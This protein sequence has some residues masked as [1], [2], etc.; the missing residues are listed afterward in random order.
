VADRKAKTAMDSLFS[1]GGWEKLYVVR[2]DASRE[3]IY[4]S[5]DNLP[6]TAA[7]ARG[8]TAMSNLLAAL[9][10]SLSFFPI[11]RE[12]TVA[13]SWHHLVALEFDER[14]RTLV[15]NWNRELAAA[16]NIDTAAVDLAF[17]DRRPATKNVLG[18]IATSSSTTR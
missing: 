3:E 8:T 15:P 4:I 10:P 16:N 14:N 2:G 7:K 11:K 12:S 1:E 18:L 6:C 13:L 17:A 5:P 9:Y